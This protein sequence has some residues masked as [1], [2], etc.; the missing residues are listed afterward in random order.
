MTT[1]PDQTGGVSPAAAFS[2]LANETRVAIL[3][4]LGESGERDPRRFPYKP[5]DTDDPEGLS[6]SELRARADVN[7]SGRFNYHLGKLLDVFV[8]QSGDTYRLSWLGVLAFR[9]VVA[10]VL[11][12][13]VTLE[14]FETD[15]ACGE[16]G[17]PLEASYPRGRLF[18][19]E[20]PD[21]SCRVAG[22]DIPTHA[23][24]NRSRAELLRV[25]DKR[26]RAQLSLLRDGI[27]YWCAGRVDGAVH[28]LPSG[29]VDG[30]RR[31]Q[32]VVTLLCRDCGG[33][34]FP[35]VGSVVA[36]DPRVGAFLVQ[37]TTDDADD[38]FCWEWPFTTA[39]DAVTLQ[40]TDP[41]VLTV[42]VVAEDDARLAVTVDETGTVAGV[43][44]R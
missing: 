33:V 20:C 11:H 3:R 35:S 22:V 5:F 16:C 15:S 24:R 42:D 26:Q 36:T 19:L 29:T 13:Q 40:S 21:C 25:V 27:C 6:Y 14:P 2:R 34:R 38:R 28:R 31:T 23:V 41:L 7:D 8:E 10:G 44:R 37:H 18:V 9:F 4:A 30:V 1:P 12:D 39:S 17:T 43:E 32:P